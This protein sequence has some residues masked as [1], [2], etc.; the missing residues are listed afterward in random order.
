VLNLDSKHHLNPNLKN[1]INQGGY[2]VIYQAE[3]AG[4][5]YA[6]K[7]LNIDTKDPANSINNAIK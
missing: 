4:R 1:W 3:M 7:K 6:I 2:G 5:K